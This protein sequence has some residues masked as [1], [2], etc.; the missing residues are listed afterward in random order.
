MLAVLPIKRDVVHAAYHAHLVQI[1]A[2]PVI[3]SLSIQCWTRA[4]VDAFPE[5][6]PSADHKTAKAAID[7]ISIRRQTSAGRA[8]SFAK[9]VRMKQRDAHSVGTAKISSRFAAE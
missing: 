5:T 9:R 8:V 2:S 4:L 6:H 1:S 3:P 7:F